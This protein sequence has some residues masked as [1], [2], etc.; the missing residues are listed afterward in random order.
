MEKQFY[1]LGNSEEMISN[2]NRRTK[3]I[4]FEYKNIRFVNKCS[5]CQYTS[6]ETS[7]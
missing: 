6:M 1:G 2:F 7:L 4:D 5:R 3:K